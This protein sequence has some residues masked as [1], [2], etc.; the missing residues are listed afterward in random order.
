MNVY[1]Y[2]LGIWR[3]EV[4]NFLNQMTFSEA[5]F[6]QIQF[7][8]SMHKRQLTYADRR[9]EKGWGEIHVWMPERMVHLALYTYKYSTP[10]A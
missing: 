9:Q 2:N 5:C 1:Y 6:M 7:P 8:S 4:R 3:S 10:A